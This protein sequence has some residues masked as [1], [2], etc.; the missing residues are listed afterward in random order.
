MA[1]QEREIILYTK[2]DCPLCEEGKAVLAIL[3]NESGET[4]REVDI[5]TNDTFLE[6]YQL[7]IP[8]VAVDG[9]DVAWGRLSFASLVEY[10]N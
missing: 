4:F 1:K 7:M 2:R 8:V 6:K 10:F 5:Y 9:K 3:C